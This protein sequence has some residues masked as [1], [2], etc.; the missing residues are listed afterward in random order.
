M[1]GDF[2]I[3]KKIVL[4]LQDVHA[5][6][7]LMQDDVDKGKKPLVVFVSVGSSVSGRSENLE[8]IATLKEHH[9]FWLHVDG[10]NVAALA[11]NDTP[12]RFRFIADHADSAVLPL[13]HWL[14][15]TSVPYVVSFCFYFCFFCFFFF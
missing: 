5:L 12:D 7:K 1:N 6:E 11:L 13:G 2:L 4:F 3:L 10:L 15:V 14:G 8:Q 9:K